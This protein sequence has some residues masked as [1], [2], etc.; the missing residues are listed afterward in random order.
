MCIRDRID[1][2]L[3]QKPD[4]EF[5]KKSSSF[6]NKIEEEARSK[7]DVETCVAPSFQ[8]R[9]LL[10]KGAGGLLNLNDP[11]V[12]NNV[13][14]N[15]YTTTKTGEGI[16]AQ[17]EFHKDIDHIMNKVKYDYQKEQRRNYWWNKVK[18]FIL[19]GIKQ[20]DIKIPDKP[21]NSHA[22][23]PGMALTVPFWKKTF[24][25]YA[26]RKIGTTEQKVIAEQLSLIHI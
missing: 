24:A 3:K 11:D 8:A 22:Y 2:A 25:Y 18:N 15:A 26:D 23:K 12:H 20:P 7:E 10:L 6:L 1:I 21:V 19:P 13:V 14:M 5:L 9:V 16:D 4:I 17:E